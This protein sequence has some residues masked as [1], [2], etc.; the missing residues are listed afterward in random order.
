MTS[1]SGDEYDGGIDE[2]DRDQVEA[3]L[4]VAIAA[5]LAAKTATAPWLALAH[6]RLSGIL[7]AYLQR[8]ALAMAHD[9]GLPAGE[10]AEAASAAV[11]GVLG[12]VERHTAAWLKIAAEDH[13][14]PKVMDRPQA[15][16]SAGVIARSL[17]T[18]ARERVREHVAQTLGAGFK[19]WITR[20]DSRVRP[21]HAATAGTTLSIGRPFVMEGH[22]VMYPGD[23]HAPLNLIAGCRCH[24]AYSADPAKAA[25]AR[26]VL[27]PGHA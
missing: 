26:K 9:A 12:D 3:A 1:P 22:D 6:D 21:A 2:Q 4:A 27:T 19:T 15:D 20:A 14:S 17:A 5:L 16:Q 23:P 10:A 11:S 25:R 13:S 24:L 8:S 18:Y 7:T